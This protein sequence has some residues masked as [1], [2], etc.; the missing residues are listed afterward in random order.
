M[1]FISRTTTPYE[2]YYYAYFRIILSR[3]EHPFGLMHTLASQFIDLF[4]LYLLIPS[5]S[6]YLSVSVHVSVSLLV[7][8]GVGVM[9]FPCVRS[10][11]HVMSTGSRLPTVSPHSSVHLESRDISLQNCKH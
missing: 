7:C 1:Q 6:V 5:P 3:A 4:S 9:L 8:L 10:A 2:R 11:G